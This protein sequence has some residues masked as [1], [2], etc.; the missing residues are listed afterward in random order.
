MRPYRYPGATNL[1]LLG[2]SLCPKGQFAAVDP[3]TTIASTTA[4]TAL[5]CLLCPVGNY[6]SRTDAIGGCTPCGAGLT[7]LAMGATSASECT[8]P[9]GMGKDPATSKCTGCA[10]GQYQ[11]PDG[12]ACVQCPDP[13][14]VTAA[15]A[16]ALQDCLCRAG[17]LKA[18]S[19][20][21]VPCPMGTFSAAPTAAPRCTAC[22]PGQTTAGVGAAAF[23]ACVCNAA[24]GFQKGSGGLCR[25]T[26]GQAG[27]ATTP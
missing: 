19:T 17:F 22:Q 3:S 27:H 24:A 16:R 10:L 23:A 12:K 14:M 15:G 11:S 26:A 25:S 5:Q 2:C 7:T 4:T 9:P 18:S 13:N 21:C 6:S 20:A 8:C 1:Q